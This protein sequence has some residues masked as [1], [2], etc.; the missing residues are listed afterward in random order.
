M[1]EIQAELRRIGL[2]LYDLPGLAISGPVSDFIDFLRSVPAGATWREVLRDLPEHWIPGQHET[3]F[4]EDE[5]EAADDF[6]GDD[7]D[8]EADPNHDPRDD[9]ESRP[10]VGFRLKSGAYDVHEFFAAV[11]QHGDHHD[12]MLFEATDGEVPGC[13]RFSWDTSR[14]VVDAMAAWMRSLPFVVF[15]SSSYGGRRVL[16]TDDDA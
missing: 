12:A 2:D 9:T 8:A 11:T 14:E 1:R 13:I 16:P 7:L 5:S 6:D 15:V 4:D 10:Q 3:W